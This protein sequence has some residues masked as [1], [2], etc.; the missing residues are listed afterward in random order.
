MKSYFRLLVLFF[1]CI[2]TQASSQTPSDEALR[3]R[4]KKLAQE[5]IIVD[6][7]ID[8]PEQMR[9]K[10]QDISKRLPEGEFDYPRAKEGGL[11]APFMS[12]FTGADEETKGTAYKSAEEMI[13]MVY[14]FS[15]DWPDKFA[16]ASSVSDVTRQTKREKLREELSLLWMSPS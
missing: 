15:K 10:W 9:E 8:A 13:E 7:H 6:T 14:K 2:L 4:A 11:K 16:V 3:A 5:F 12:I 1:V